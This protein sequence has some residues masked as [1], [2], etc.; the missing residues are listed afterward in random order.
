MDFILRRP[1]SY[2][3]KKDFVFGRTLGRGTFG[4]VKEATWSTRDNLH[5]AIKVILK[6]SIKGQHQLI[7]DEIDVLQGLDHPNVVKF[8]EWFESKTKFYLV[9]QLAN[10]GELFERILERGKFTEADSVKAIKAVLHGVQYLHSNE[11]VHRDLKPENL[12]LE[13]PDSDNLLI[14]DFGIARHMATPDE[15]LMSMAGSPGYAAPEVL[16]KKGHGKPVDMW[17]VGVI[18]YTLL[19]GYSPF[20]ADSRQELI[21]E[22]TRA[23][24]E[25]HDKYWGKVSDQAKNFILAL[26]KADPAARLTAEEALRHSWLSEGQGRN[27]YDLSGGLRENWSARKRWRMAISGVQAAVRLSRGVSISSSL[28]N[29]TGNVSGLRMSAEY[30][31]ASEDEEGSEANRNTAE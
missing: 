17:A 12:L 6:K 11:V 22:T 29:A 25:F 27:V 10:G 1:E 28:S 15:V 13:A 8:Y 31:T 7:Y 5:V 18:T 20:R 23:R 4:E 2:R 21:N 16:N 30:T 14:A 3:K 9:F 26:I 24:V 19:C